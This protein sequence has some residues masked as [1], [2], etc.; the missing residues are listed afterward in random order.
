[1]TTL[2]GL[3]LNPSEPAGNRI[4]AAAA[5][6]A[7]ERPKPA[8]SLAVDFRGAGEAGASPSLDANPWDRLP[9][10]LA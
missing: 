3:Y 6:I 8:T 10:S 4:K 2:Q 9:R 5:A 1:L 7:Y